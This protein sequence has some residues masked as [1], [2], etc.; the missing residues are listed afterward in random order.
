MMASPEEELGGGRSAQRLSE[1]SELSA[2]IG[3]VLQQPLHHL[4][5]SHAGAERRAALAS[6]ALVPTLGRVAANRVAKGGMSLA[7]SRLCLIP[8]LRRYRSHRGP[9]A[10]SRRGGFRSPEPPRHPAGPRREM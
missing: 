2:V 8:G 3:I 6:D 7:Q 9:V 1:Q 5:V 4:G 10:L